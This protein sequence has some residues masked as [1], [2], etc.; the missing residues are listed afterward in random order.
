MHRG[1]GT[2]D[3]PAQQVFASEQSL[4]RF[5][6][7]KRIRIGGTRHPGCGPGGEKYMPFSWSRLAQATIFSYGCSGFPNISVA[8]SVL[9]GCGSAFRNLPHARCGGT[10][11]VARQILLYRAIAVHFFIPVSV[12]P[13]GPSSD[14]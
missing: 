10:V 13:A 11:W 7:R 14:G 4:F 3:D 6:Y 5:R 12:I 9:D 2:F 8:Q 1:S